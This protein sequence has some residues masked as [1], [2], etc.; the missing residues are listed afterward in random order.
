[1]EHICHRCGAVLNEGA[2]F[3]NQCG[4]PQVRVPET[5]T[6]TTATES[7]T[8]SNANRVFAPSPAG[9]VNWTQGRKAAAIAALL[10][11]FGALIPP[12]NMVLPLWMLVGGWICVS[13]YRRRT[14]AVLVPAATGAKLGAL[15]GV[16]GF[17]YVA[18]LLAIVF[19]VEVIALKNGDQLRS[20][21]KAQIEQAAASNPS[22]AQALTQLLQTPE[23]ITTLIISVLF[24][25]FLLFLLLS[26]AGGI[27]GAAFGRQRMR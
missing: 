19:A 12:L 4:A 17:I 8:E 10:M 14:A 3:C 9:S 24:V 6:T 27:F 22:G 15:A 25:M 7:G 16:I 20:L 1:V 26:C 5:V 18:A 13:L 23:G 11:A 21:L 2:A